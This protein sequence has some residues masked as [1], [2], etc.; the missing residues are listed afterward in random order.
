[1]NPLIIFD[2]I[3]YRLAILFGNL[4]ENRYTDG[5]IFIGVMALSFM[6]FVSIMAILNHIEIAR[7]YIRSLY[8]YQYVIGYVV[9]IGLNSIR[10]IKLLKFKDLEEKWKSEN[11]LKKI[12]RSILILVYFFASCYFLAP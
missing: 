3:F 8:Y 6:Q 5:N 10:Y 4:P 11:T 7:V 9:F 1:M 12:F 2:Y